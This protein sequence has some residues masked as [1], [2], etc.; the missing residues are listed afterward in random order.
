MFVTN[1]S[2]DLRAPLELTVGRRL[3]TSEPA[4]CNLSTW[5]WLTITVLHTAKINRNSRTC[6]QLQQIRDCAIKKTVSFSTIKDPT[7]CN[8]QCRIFVLNLKSIYKSDFDFRNEES[9]LTLILVINRE[10]P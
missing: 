5:G 10:T 9:I 7:S 6:W 4:T 3:S 1:L 8:T 2:L